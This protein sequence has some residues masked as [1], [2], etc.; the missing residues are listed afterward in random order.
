LLFNFNNLRY[1]L[2]MERKREVAVS[3][4]VAGGE[5]LVVR[6]PSGAGKSTLLR[7]LARLQPC[8]GGEAFLKG[9]S[10]REIPGTEW[11]SEVHY[12]AQKP[13]LFDG[14]V[15]DNLALPFESRMLRE[16]KT[17]DLERV[18]VY[19]EKL[20]LSQPGFLR[21]DARTLSGGEAARLVF[22]RAL[23]VGPSVLLLDEPAAPLDGKSRE[24]FYRVLS[25]W[26]NA[27][28]RAAVLVSHDGDYKYLDK[29]S[30]LDITA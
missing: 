29:F 17:F 8:I 26:L 24:A 2:G 1:S 5:V 25:G 18:K 9:R 28:G 12:V 19:L 13:V 7:I 30:F 3:G 14:T 15:A 22:A 11:R 16:K 27:S 6:G 4:S 10:W 23:L 20:L 21:Q